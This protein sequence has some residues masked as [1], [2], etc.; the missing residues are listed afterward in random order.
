MDFAKNTGGGLS[1]ITLPFVS[2]IVPTYRR[3]EMLVETVRHLLDQDYPAYEII[4]VDQ[5]E[6][7]IG[8]DPVFND[9]R[10]SY[11]TILERGP[12]AAKNFGIGRARGD[13]IL[14]VDD[15][16][17]PEPDLI[18]R[19][20]DNYDDPKIGAV[21]GRVFSPGDKE[22]DHE[23]IGVMRPNGIA[24]GNYTSRVRRPIF[25]VIGCNFSFRR[26]V[27]E[28]VGP[29]DT[30]YIGNF[31]REESDLCARIVKAGHTIMYD[32]EA[33]IVHLRAP[34][35]GC[36]V[37]RDLIWHFYFLHN[38]TLFFLS[39]MKR[40]FLPFFLYEHIR[41]AVV[42]SYHHGKDPGILLS[43]MRGMYLGLRTYRTGAVD[44]VLLGRYLRSAGTFQ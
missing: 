22:T 19:H 32:P 39:H 29:Y 25:T 37:E 11:F 43:L 30:R 38:S 18:A 26:R 28:A 42:Y 16:I 5:S 33:R 20:V 40:R 15:D 6:E 9:T 12:Q 14:T 36:R 41:R 1:K 3:Q 17:V 21:G 4:V 34:S 7:A 31:V 27:F 2:V 10:V 35:G 44:T 24:I 8:S 13:I 23:T